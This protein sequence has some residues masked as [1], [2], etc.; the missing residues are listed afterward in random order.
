MDSRSKRVR[1]GVILFLLLVLIG[2]A[3]GKI[4]NETAYGAVAHPRAVA[5]DTDV[6]WKGAEVDIKPP[7]G[8]AGPPPP[9]LL[10]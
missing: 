10:R 3:V 2:Y 9:S 8:R 1:R 6:P 5:C 7:G 4:F